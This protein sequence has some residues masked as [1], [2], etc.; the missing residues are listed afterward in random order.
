MLK[1]ESILAFA[2]VAEAGS[3]S[4]AA[5]RLQISK[6][7]A[8]E[9]L[10]ELERSLG[11]TLVH[12]TTR[13]LSL[14]EN[15]V[16]FLERAKRILREVTDATVEVSELSGE[17]AGPLRISAPVS[18]GSLHLGPALYSF[19][20]QHP[21]IELSLELDDRF[22]GAADGFD[23][24][25]RHGPLPDNASVVNPLAASK[26]MLVASPDY[27]KRNGAPRSIAELQRHRGIIFANRGAS[28]WRFKKS[29]RWSAVRPDKIMRVNNGI[30]M[31]DAAA[32]GLGIALLA[33][34]MVHE[35]LARKELRVVDI[36][37]EA[38]HAT[39]F[40]AYPSDRRVSAK[41]LAMIAHLRTAFG[42]PPYWDRIPS[43]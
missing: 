25:V 30:V 13:R 27:L 34:F 18:F 43:R 31:R 2:A 42:T 21:R 24:I 17:L 38:E 8:S 29:G 12:R 7:V 26:R 6:S 36:G 35:A 32:A 33:S 37:A 15:G 16:A 39:I 20:R 23:A 41:V 1:L 4:E 11:A 28:D 3:I 19:L 5:R 10:S 14:T 9:R 22:V 40:V